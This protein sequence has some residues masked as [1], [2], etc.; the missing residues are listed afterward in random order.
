MKSRF[1]VIQES[2]NNSSY[3]FFHSGPLPNHLAFLSGVN[4]DHHLFL[5]FMLF[6]FFGGNLITSTTTGNE[7]DVHSGDT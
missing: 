1:I 7:H 5:L 6:I 3:K 4:I 2:H